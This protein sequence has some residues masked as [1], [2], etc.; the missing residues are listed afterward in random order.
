MEWVTGKDAFAGLVGMIAAPSP[1]GR[2]V[3]APQG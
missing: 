3:K 2:L 1:P